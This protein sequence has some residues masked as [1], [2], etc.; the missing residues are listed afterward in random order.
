MKFYG[1]FQSVASIRDPYS[2]NFT[3]HCVFGV[4]FF[5]P[6][7]FSCFR[8][9]YTCNIPASPGWPASESTVGPG[10][11]TFFRI[12]TNI[13]F[14]GRILRDPIRS[15][16]VTR[17]LPDP[18]QSYTKFQPG[19]LQNLPLPSGLSCPVPEQFSLFFVLVMVAH[20]HQYIFEFSQPSLCSCQLVSLHNQFKKKNN[21]CK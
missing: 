16:K 10:S 13:P 5:T 21:Q 18:V 9:R 7:Q 2:Q 14:L 6:K 11:Y 1:Y 8:M 4:I 20:H 12:L 3:V 17:F 19:C 15:N